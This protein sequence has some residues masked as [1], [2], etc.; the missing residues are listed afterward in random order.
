[1]PLAKQVDIAKA[2]TLRLERG[3]TYQ[4]IATL[5]G[6]TDSAIHAALKPLLK[7]LEHPT[8]VEGY[9]GKEASLLDGARMRVLSHMMD[10][11]KLA[12]CP[13][14]HLAYTHRQLFDEARLLRDQS[15]SNVGVRANVVLRAHEQRR[16]SLPQT[17]ADESAQN[18]QTS[19][20]GAGVRG[21]RDRE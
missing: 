8:A 16:A 17:S 7:L 2:L 15:T 3:L 11:E 12:K 9:R 6:V 19:E 4:Q 14:N 5:Q 21:D 10:D 20:G 18:D 1:M 13:P